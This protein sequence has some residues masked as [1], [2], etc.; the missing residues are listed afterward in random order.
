M[1]IV[2]ITGGLGNQMFQY[3][4]GRAASL[5]NKTTL[6]LNIDFFRGAFTKQ[7][8]EQALSVEL[9]PEIQSQHLLK[10][11]GD[12]LNRIED[13]SRGFIRRKYN[14][15][16][17]SFGLSTSFKTL[18]ETQLLCFQPDF[19][20]HKADTLYLASDWQNEK[21][22]SDYE[23]II[24]KDFTFPKIETSSQNYFLLENINKTNSVS[25]HVRRGDY[26][27]SVTHQPTSLDYYKQAI[28][29]VLSKIINPCFFIFSDDI[30]WC[31]E[32]LA[33]PNALYINH[34]IGENSYLDMQL[35]SNC[36]HNI[37]ANS[38]FS[39]WGAWLNINP[40]KLVIAPNI[41]LA[42]HHIK[43]ENIIPEYWIN[44]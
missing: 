8:H 28:D 17:N 10:L 26:L 11:T 27:L 14:R 24:R 43:S 31:Q 18:A 41:W 42:S 21:Y 38:S 25:I 16:R 33:I 22:F 32:N 3:S 37:I 6:A 36:K 15:I 5:R 9:F 23:S 1:I 19:K 7:I 12:D 20:Q 29:L 30:G 13:K 34:N 4:A 35:M 2:R 39:W 40:S 44:L